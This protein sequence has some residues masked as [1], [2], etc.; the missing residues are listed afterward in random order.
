M[1]K[2]FLHNNSLS[3]AVLCLFF[4]FFIGQALVGWNDF[5]HDRQDRHQTPITLPHYLTTGAFGESVF[6]NWESEFLQMGIYVILTAKFVQRGSAESKDPDQPPQEKPL[7]PQSPKAVHQGGWIAWAYS[8]SLSA[9]LLFLF[10]I[11]FTGHAVC[12]A[13]SYSDELQ[14]HGRPPITTL[15]YMATSR[16]WFESFQNWQSE[17]LSIGALVILSIWLREK[18]S[19]ESK[20]VNAP[21]AQTGK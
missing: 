18:D 5:N 10:V 20:E 13:A 16:F 19:P 1:R 2:N 7:T 4:F 14:A 6:E 9:A 3:I 17:F 11:S 21:H 15:Q 8:H 12:G